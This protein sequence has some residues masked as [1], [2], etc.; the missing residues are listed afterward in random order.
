MSESKGNCHT[1]GGHLA[2]PSEMLGQKPMCPHCECET[3]LTACFLLSIFIPIVEE[4]CG[5]LKNG[6]AYFRLFQPD[7]LWSFFRRHGV[8]RV[9]WQF[10]PVVVVEPYWGLP[11]PE[12]G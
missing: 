2:F 9:P 3:V 10:N 8:G 11:P 12:K 5:F 6:S 1:C 7:R 4:F